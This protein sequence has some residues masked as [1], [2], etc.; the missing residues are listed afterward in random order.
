MLS[1]V[2]GIPLLTASKNPLSMP[3]MWSMIMS[4]PRFI[5]AMANNFVNCWENLFKL[6]NLVD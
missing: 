4:I 2:D 5:G 1:V 3:I 6:E